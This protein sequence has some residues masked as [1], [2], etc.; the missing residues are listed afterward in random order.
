MSWF[1]AVSGTDGSAYNA[2]SF[3]HGSPLFTVTLPGFSVAVGGN[4]DTCL[5]ESNAEMSSGWVVVGLGILRTSTQISI[6][7]HADWARLLARESFDPT[8]LDGHF[9]ILRWKGGLLECFTD[10]LG[11]RT[12]YFG[13]SQNAVFISTRLDWLARTIKH[14]EIDFASFGSRW[15][16][17]NQ[18]SYNSCIAGIERVGPGGHATFRLGSIL[19]STCTPWLPSFHPAPAT[20]P[21]E[22]L[23]EFV[24][25][26]LAYKYTPS[27]GLSGG[28]DSRLLCSVFTNS[29][30]ERFITHTFGAPDDPDVR[31]ALQITKALGLPNRHLNDPLPDVEQ[32]IQAVQ[33]FVAQT[34]LVE[35]CTSY[36]K[37]RYYPNL[38]DEG[39]LMIDGG[40][41]EIARRQY[42]NRVVRLGRSALKARDASRLIQL[43]QAPRADIFS[44]ETTAL[45][46][47]GALTGLQ[48]T[49]N[50]MPAV[51]SI[52]VGNFADLLA[53]RTRVPNF[54]GPEQ[55]RIDG[56]IINFMPLVQ[57]SFLRAAFGIP[58]RLRA[59]AGLYHGFIRKLNPPLARF[60]LAKG[61][62]THRFGF[63]SNTAWLST[64]LKS[65]LTQ[66]YSDPL[67]DMLLTH[68]REFVLDIAHSK[69]IATS[70]FY[71][72]RHVVNAVDGYYRGEHHLRR[73]VDWW[74]T[75]ELWKRSLSG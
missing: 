24:R 68:I 61:G 19:N 34:M 69:D 44:T 12:V 70:S 49:L 8:L 41:G 39:R 28:L 64:K 3:C 75:F 17:F 47:R 71:D 9:A 43:M 57:P 13:T 40:F 67:P 7:S 6:M 11:L 32:C 38:H 45:L 58:A 4:P 74:L 21:I 22:I 29:S 2:A 14:S 30:P 35:P 5:W 73:T 27:L 66:G 37:L 25:C 48:N 33:S 36:L 1:S 31:I 55:A 42:L 51:E 10:Q 16:L 63:S 18:V 26:A 53:V 46:E 54:G 50:E 60:P 59:N 52:G 23:Q 15:L 20:A 72:S 65:F 56:E 62:F